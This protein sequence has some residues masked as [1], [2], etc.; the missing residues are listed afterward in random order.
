MGVSS[1]CCKAGYRGLGS[2]G[3][4]YDGIADRCTY[5][6]IIPTR[7]RMPLKPN[8]VQEMLEKYFAK[9]DIRDAF[10][11]YSTTPS[12]CTWS[13]GGGPEIRAGDDGGTRTRQ[14]WAPTSHSRMS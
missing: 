10:T 12:G 7:Y 14:R 5:A 13:S 4:R 6:R 2:G 9:A 11:T 1:S 8:V 3:V